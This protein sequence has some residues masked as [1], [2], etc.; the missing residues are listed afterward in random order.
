MSSAELI[1]PSY[2]PP[3]LDETQIL[4]LARD[5]FLT[6]S[7]SSTHT[8]CLEELF[9]EIRSFF[10][11]DEKAKTVAYPPSEGME[12]GYAQLAGEKEYITFRH[13][14]KPDS[15]EPLE[16]SS[17]IAWDLTA[18]LLHRVLCDLS[19]ALEIPL[20]AWDPLLDGCLSMPEK[21][22][23]STPTLLR[24]FNYLPSAGTAET[25]SDIGFL[26][27]CLGTG[28]GL[29]VRPR[30]D[31]TDDTNGE[32][33]RSNSYL[34]WLDVSTQPTILIG[35]TLSLLSGGRLKT[36]IH[37]VTANPL[38]RQSIVFALRPSLRHP[39]LDLRP[40]GEENVVEI[41]DVWRRIRASVF[42]VN[43]HK[44]DRE[45]Q[46]RTL[47]AKGLNWAEQG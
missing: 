18:A 43:A 22:D 34:P 39:R 32:T 31:A 42:N 21:M 3:L 30:L 10:S 44:A 35:K 16:R 6:L 24:L 14:I 1:A 29:Q 26:T 13:Y 9:I 25:H 41:A 20:E 7:L 8:Q 28:N 46:K 33:D 2:P 19:S 12:K 45:S 17:K 5:G 40:F 47:H 4:S 37:R 23:Q 38:G 36:G 15:P 11:K 27:L